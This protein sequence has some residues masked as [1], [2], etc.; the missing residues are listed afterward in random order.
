MN[1]MT[2]NIKQNVKFG[3]DY[4][5]ATWIRAVKVNNSE[6]IT[7]EDVE[8]IGS[9]ISI[10]NGFFNRVLKSLFTECFDEDLPVNKNRY[11]Y[12]FSSEGRYL[13]GFQEEI[14][15]HNFYTYKQMDNLLESISVEKKDYCKDDIEQLELFVSY[16]RQIMTECHDADY[17]SVMS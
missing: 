7:D 9:E 4:G 17:I 16:V 13:K 6:K 2:E 5:A 11:T 10:D 14:L 1:E 12:T 15:E 3:H 8:E